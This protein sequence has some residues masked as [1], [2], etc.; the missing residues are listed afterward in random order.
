MRALSMHFDSNLYSNIGRGLFA[1]TC[2]NDA[3]LFTCRHVT[4]GVRLA[5]SICHDEGSV[6][7]ATGF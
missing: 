5:A 2:F 6:I 1:W 7:A 3:A 4:T